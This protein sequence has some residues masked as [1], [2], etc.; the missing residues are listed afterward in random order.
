MLL[1]HL[2]TD[3]QRYL[4]LVDAFDAGV[5]LSGWCVCLTRRDEPVNLELVINNLPVAVTAANILR[6]DVCAQFSLEG[7]YGFCFEAA[8]FDRFLAHRNAFQGKSWAVR[9]AG[10][11]LVLPV[12]GSVGSLSDLLD[13]RETLLSFDSSVA[14]LGRLGSLYDEASPL[15]TVPFQNEGAAAGHIEAVAP[16]ANNIQWFIGW[17]ARQLARNFSGVFLDRRKFRAG[18]VL[19]PFERPDL[20]RE[21]V[22]VVGAILTDWRPSLTTDAILQFGEKGE[23]HLHANRNLR[24]T[25]V[26]DVMEHLERGKEGEGSPMVAPLREFSQAND[27]WE[28]ASST[29]AKVKLA[30]DNASALEGFGVFMKGWIFSP[31]R[32]V[33]SIELKW[34]AQTHPC[35]PRS[36][37]FVARPD[38]QSAFPTSS[39]AVERAGFRCIFPCEAVS[40]DIDALG[41]K[42]VYEDG[43]ASYHLLSDTV[44]NRIAPGQDGGP[45]REFYPNM[46]N[47]SFFGDYAKAYYAMCVRLYSACGVE[48][49]IKPAA[50]ALVFVAPSER[51]SLYLLFEELRHKLSASE[52]QGLAL[53]VVAGKDQ[54]HGEI[55]ELFAQLSDAFSGPSNLVFVADAQ[56]AL[57]ALDSIL[58]MLGASYFVFIGPNVILEWD[59]WMGIAEL[60]TTP[61]RL[62]FLEVTNPCEPWGEPEKSMNAFAWSSEQFLAWRRTNRLPIGAPLFS[63]SITDDAEVLAGCGTNPSRSSR[64]LIL[65]AIDRHAGV[66]N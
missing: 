59:G 19:A 7:R 65:S 48:R 15:V 60:L 25:G 14:L 20:P 30:V 46:E 49:N 41:L 6:A 2:N 62:A 54:R 45:F 64:T 26:R 8:L 53:V 47:E 37:H 55:H 40:K 39:E 1:S 32:V 5:G 28:L 12:A 56:Y 50:R 11:S 29:A 10:S 36:L 63:R 34:G 43:C 16:G 3:G 24:L 21:A 44:V 58:V 51:H 9:A 42:I 17:M 33:K 57:W 31:S 38:L 66:R 52:T 22:G 35:D 4:G 18:V 13:R 61:P 23:R 27:S